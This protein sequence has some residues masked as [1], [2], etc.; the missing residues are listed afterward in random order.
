MFKPCITNIWLTSC[1]TDPKLQLFLP[2]CCCSV[3]KIQYIKEKTGTITPVVIQTFFW[4]GHR[5]AI[6]FGNGE[7]FLVMN[8]SLLK[9]YG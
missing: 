3:K 7:G 6:N 1:K 4:Y 5:M 2:P 8:P 9:K